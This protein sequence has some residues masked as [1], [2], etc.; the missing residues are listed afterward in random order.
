MNRRCLAAVV[1]AA[2]G[3]TAGQIPAVG[4]AAAAAPDAWGQPEANATGDHY[5]PGETRLT[6]AVAPKLKPRWKVPLA[7]ATCATAGEPLVGG[8]RLVTAASYRISGYDAS[9]GK[10][11]WQTPATGKKT[12]I[13]LTAIA[14]TRLVAQSR[15]CRSGKTFLS[16]QAVKTGK[17]L[18]SKRIP[19]TM[20]GTLV[21][22]GIVVGGVWDATISKYAIRAYRITDGTPVWARVGSIGGETV[23][24]GG[25][26]LVVG[27]D[28]TTAVDVTT[29]KTLWTAGAGCFTPIGASPNGSTFYMRCGPDEQIRSVDAATGA[30]L[31]TFPTHGGTFGFATDGER[32]YLHTYD[33]ELIAVDAVDGHKVWTATFAEN[34]PI[35]TSIGGGVVYGWRGKDHPLTAFETATGKAIQL[36][37]TTSALRDA[38]LVANGRLYGATGAAVTAYA[39]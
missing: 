27:E 17:V 29:G 10:R 9:T 13:S 5:N 19:E 33:N 38:P 34:A 24:A 18:Y 26:I 23:A 8:N 7:D 35:I 28:K 4:P 22:K 1:I 2:I 16:A 30:T 20:Y 39:P 12:D 31:E 32:V 3:A 6:P 15:D 36:A 14:G 21:D 25:R 37:A 11:V